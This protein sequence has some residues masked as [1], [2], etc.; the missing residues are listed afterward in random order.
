MSRFGWGER[1]VVD[2]KKKKKKTNQ[3]TV[4]VF[5]AI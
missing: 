3:L 2:I 4:F 5:K 1:V